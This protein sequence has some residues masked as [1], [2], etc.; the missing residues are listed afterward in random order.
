MMQ[1]AAKFR[2]A[3][4]TLIDTPGAYPGPEAEQRGIA[5]ALARN[6]Q[7][8][9]V[10]PTPVV[11]A[12]IGEGG[13]G[14][15]LSLGVADRV[16]MLEHAIYS[17]IAPEGAAAILWRDA[18]KAAEVAEALKITAADLRRLGVI[19]GIVPEPRGGAHTDPDLAARH[20]RAA[21]VRALRSV[22]SV[23]LRVLLRRRARKYRHIGRVGA[24]W[25]QV[26]RSEMQELLE[27]LG[28]RLLRREPEVGATARREDGGR[29]S[30]R[31]RDE[32][33]PA[34]EPPAPE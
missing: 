18:G 19:D 10:L 15:A 12:V 28:D 30:R 33:G 3:V 22:R 2:L 5:Q 11:A 9:A 21:L 17:V 14:G 34:P 6:L 27:G 23:P 32:G 29:R 25:R 31:S 16:L 13:S 24:Y 7:A 1:L 20:L 26:V 8:M 4:I